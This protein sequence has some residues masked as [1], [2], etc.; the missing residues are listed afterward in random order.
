MKG[1]IDQV[2]GQIRRAIRNMDK[3]KRD[4]RLCGGVQVFVGEDVLNDLLAGGGLA[5][6]PYGNYS[7]DGYPVMMA[8]GYPTG[9]IAAE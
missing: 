5:R 6:D 7:L 2:M 8:K 3:F 1:S 9:Y 4:N